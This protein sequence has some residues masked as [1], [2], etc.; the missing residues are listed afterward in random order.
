MIMSNYSK[1]GAIPHKAKVF[2]LLELQKLIDTGQLEPKLFKLL[3]SDCRIE[4][5]QQEKSNG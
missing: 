3:E 4:L 5:A 2:L 1:V